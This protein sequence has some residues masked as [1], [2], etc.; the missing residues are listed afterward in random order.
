[1]AIGGGD[2]WQ[3]TSLSTDILQTRMTIRSGDESES[4][5]PAIAGCYGT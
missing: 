5:S 3:F 2:H 1:M 4:R